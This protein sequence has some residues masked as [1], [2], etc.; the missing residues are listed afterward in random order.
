M[1]VSVFVGVCVC[2]C[3]GVCGQDNTVRKVY[4]LNRVT[5]VPYDSMPAAPIAKLFSWSL[6]C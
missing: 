5:D 2:V 6:F 1:C 4:N 3:G